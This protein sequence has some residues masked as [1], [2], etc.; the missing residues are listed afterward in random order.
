M[1]IT[2]G[3]EYIDKTNLLLETIEGLIPDPSGK[4]RKQ[5]V[6]SEL[7]IS[8]VSLPCIWGSLGNP[9]YEDISA[10]GFLK[11]QMEG[12]I[13]KRYYMREAKSNF[14]LSV[15]TK[16]KSS[17]DKNDYIINGEKLFLQNK[18]ACSAITELVRK[19]IDENRES[20]VTE[21]DLDNP[22]GNKFVDFRIQNI[23]F[24]FEDGPNFWSSLIT[25]DATYY[26]I[27]VEEFLAGSLINSYELTTNILN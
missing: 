9:A 25:G 24:A 20:F 21:K 2:I 5:W 19:A 17:K 22:T 15:V 13:F 18:L 8:D 26:T 14:S 11:E 4:N 12:N 23:E 27:W 16:R 1:T 6:F 10:D 3:L 7:P